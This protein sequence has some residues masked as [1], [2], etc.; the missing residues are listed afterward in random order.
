VSLDQT[1]ALADAL[2]SVVETTNASRRSSLNRMAEIGAYRFGL[3]E[4]L[5]AG[6]HLPVIWKSPSRARR[7]RSG[8]DLFRFSPFWADLARELFFLKCPG[9]FDYSMNFEIQKKLICACKWCD[10]KFCE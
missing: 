9:K 10:S 6:S 3:P 8:P 4:A 7:C 5:T 2:I 1:L